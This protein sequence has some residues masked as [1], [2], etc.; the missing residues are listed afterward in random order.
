[1]II[2][3]YKIEKPQE[4]ISEEENKSIVREISEKIINENILLL[5]N[6]DK[7]LVKRK[8]EEMLWL[9]FGK[10]DENNRIVGKVIDRIYGYGI[11]QPYIEDEITSDVRAVN[12]KDIYVKQLGK[13]KKVETRF[14]DEQDFDSYIKF[15]ALKNSANIN[16]EK[17]V[18][19]F[20]DRKNR[21]RIEAGISPVNVNSSSIIIR[22]HKENTE[23]TLEGLW[24]KEEMLNKTQYEVLLKAIKEKKNI[25][26]CGQGGSGKTTLLRAI[27]NKLPKEIAITANE[28]TAELHLK[29]RNIVQREC[30]LSREEDKNID[31]ETLAKH[32]LV[33]SNDVIVIGEMKGKE[34]NIFFDSIS[35]GHMGFATLHSDSSSSAIDRI[36]TLIKKDIKAQ[37][38]T[39]EF[40]KEYISK[41]LDIVIFLKEY[42][43]KEISELI[44]DKKEKNIVCRQYI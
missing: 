31:L 40:L 2:N 12:Y 30:I 33:M 11:L 27:L 29:N 37:Y 4:A 21:L 36:I 14:E 32:A 41:C 20:S 23:D 38:Y 9:K 24:L 10:N 42:K 22:I 28:E 15:C 13:W 17:P 7:E 39:E 43:V 5:S 44:Y 19:V 1:M 18:A 25:I 34:A 16:F 26:L 3:P 8:T 35:T 6:K